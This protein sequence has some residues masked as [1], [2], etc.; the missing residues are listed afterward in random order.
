MLLLTSQ[1][2]PGKCP[3][4]CHRKPSGWCSWCSCREAISSEWRT[5]SSCERSQWW[6]VRKR[7]KTECHTSGKIDVPLS[8][9]GIQLRNAGCVVPKGEQKS[10]TSNVKW[11][12][13]KKWI[14]RPTTNRHFI[15]SISF[16][17]KKRPLAA[18]P[19]EQPEG[20]HLICC[21]AKQTIPLTTNKDLRTP[22]FT[23]GAR[24]EGGH[25][26]SRL[27]P[28]GGVSAEHNRI[29]VKRP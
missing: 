23:A 3:W 1:R 4:I 28:S 6:T 9:W 10:L 2:Y 29:G 5:G 25:L 12:W 26:L 27:H 17:G 24:A 7:R 15:Q 19:L 18:P 8:Q 22:G 21:N 16:E 13:C 20:R 14:L 11:K